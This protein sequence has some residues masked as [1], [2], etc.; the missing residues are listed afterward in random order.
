MGDRLEFTGEFSERIVS[1]WGEDG[2]NWLA[3]FPE[4]LRDTIDKWG[5]KNLTPLENLSY[6]FVA[7]GETETGDEVILKLGV[8]NPELVSEAAALRAYA[9][10]YAVSLLDAELEKGALLLEKLSPGRMLNSLEDNQKETEIAARLM[11]ELCIPVPADS[12]FPSLTDWAKVFPRVMNDHHPEQAGLPIRL[13]E[14]AQDLIDQ[15]TRT[16]TD[17]CLLHGDLHHFNILED[18][19]RGWTVIDP[20]GVVGDKGFQAARYFGNPIPDIFAQPDLEKLTDQR[21]EIFSRELGVERERL[22]KWAFIDCIFAASWCIED[23][24]AGGV[25]NAVSTAKLFAEMVSI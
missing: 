2:Q 6:N 13:I 15:L 7:A 16:A 21:A 19:T 10:N 18:E 1:V 20:K 24:E 5:L 14:T 23:L 12:E 8:P 22:L 4:I 11:A 25:P 17:V 3:E 9:G